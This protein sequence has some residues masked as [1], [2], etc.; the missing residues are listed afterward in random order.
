MHFIRTSKIP[1]LQSQADI[2]L[3]F[4][5]FC[6]LLAALALPAALHSV[7]G[8]H[9]ALMPGVYYGWLAVILTCYAAAIEI[10]K[11]IYIRKN[12]EWL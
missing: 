2:R 6:G 5:S 11:R 10:V 3:V 4:S 9:F 8:F 12:G 7:A 1:F